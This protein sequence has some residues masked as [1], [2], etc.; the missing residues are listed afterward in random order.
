MR[1][2]RDCSHERSAPL[3]TVSTTS[4]TVP[5]KAS[6]TALKS[7]SSLR[8]TRK[9]RCGPISTLSGVGGAGF[10]PA[11]ATSPRPSTATRA[12]RSAST[13]RVA[14]DAAAAAVRTPVRSRSSVPEASTCAPVGVRAGS[15]ASSGCGD[16]GRDRP[17][18]EDDL[19][20]V[21]AGDPVDERVMGLGD[22]REAAALE[23]LDH[24]HLP[25][26]LGAVELLGED[27]PGQQEELLLGARL[28]QRGVAHVVLEAEAR[29]VDPQ[30]ATRAGGRHRE[31]L[32]IA[33]D[34]VQ[35]PAQRVEHLGVGRRRALEHR[36][37]AD[38]H[39]RR[40]PLLVQEGRVDRG[41][42][43]EMLLG[44]GCSIA[45]GGRADTTRPPRRR[46]TARSAARVC[47]GRARSRGAAGRRSPPRPRT[48]TR[49]RAR[50][51]VLLL[52]RAAATP[53]SPPSCRRVL[54]VKTHVASGSSGRVAWAPLLATSPA[55]PARRV[56]RDGA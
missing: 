30:R 43:V 26:R 24:P 2:P 10:S 9:R 27:P 55:W 6:L 33:R 29:V 41:Q 20:D 46:A 5:P 45:G 42:P 50:A 12:E 31:L 13:G 21:D 39:V 8:T 48:E 23:A 56:D 51:Q 44:H 14:S 37:R 4:L 38:V 16:L 34:E 25:Q 1:T 17:E 32:A 7:A 54:T 47:L 52:V 15:H 36:E 19:G 49:S 18:V 3:T 11:H 35:A 22:E 53:R 28:R 40:G